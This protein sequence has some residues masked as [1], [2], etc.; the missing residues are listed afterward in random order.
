MCRHDRNGGDDVSDYTPTTAAVESF[1]I[2][3][4]ATAIHDAPERMKEFRRWLAA[5]DA[6]IRADEREKAARRVQAYLT[7]GEAF[8]TRHERNIIAAARG[9]DLGRQGV[10]LAAND[11][12][13]V[14]GEQ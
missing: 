10:S 14:G 12:D 9:D 7:D 6:E 4:T 5:H 11:V 8:I 13:R 1:Y 3:M 2:G